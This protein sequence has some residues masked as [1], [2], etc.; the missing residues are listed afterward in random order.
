[1][2]QLGIFLASNLSFLCSM[3]K[4]S[5]IILIIC[6]LSSL[7]VCS[8]YSKD[9]YMRIAKKIYLVDTVLKLFNDEWERQSITKVTSYTYEST[10]CDDPIVYY[11]C[12]TMYFE[13]IPESISDLDILALRQVIDL[14]LLENTYTCNINSWSAIHGEYNNYSYLCWTVSP[15]ISCV[16]KYSPNYIETEDIFKMADSINYS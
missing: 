2:V 14:T 8:L 4:K 5:T 13:D 12:N 7:L 1:M 6:I 9:P 16:I 15:E 3:R 11:C 10:E